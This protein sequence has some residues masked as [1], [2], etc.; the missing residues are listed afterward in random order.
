M[1]VPGY[2]VYRSTVFYLYFVTYGKYYTVHE[3][4]MHKRHVTGEWGCTGDGGSTSE[5]YH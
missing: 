1:I 2:R 5:I 4:Q 3:S